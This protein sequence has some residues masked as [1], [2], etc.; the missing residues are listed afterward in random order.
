MSQTPTI[1]T[2]P[3][4][5]TSIDRLLQMFDAPDALEVAE[6]PR[7]RK[8]QIR[9]TVIVAAA[10]L[11]VTTIS[12][13]TSAVAD[14]VYA[15]QAKA[16]SIQKT[17]EIRYSAILGA[18]KK[19]AGAFNATLD[20]LT[21]TLASAVRSPAITGLSEA[22]A[23]LNT[24]LTTHSIDGVAAAR[25][26]VTNHVAAVSQNAADRALITVAASALADP[27]ARDAVTAAA[28]SLKTASPES[29]PAALRLVAAAST[30]LNVSQASAVAATRASALDAVDSQ[31]RATT[32][33]AA[34]RVKAAKAADTAD[35]NTAVANATA[36]AQAA[37]D[38]RAADLAAD[39]A[40][41]VLPVG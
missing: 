39:Q 34:A 16:A 35:L 2:E 3:T 31:V 40:A 13:A 15:S 21:D 10:V 19:S 14:T 17:A 20:G 11:T 27:D 8:A 12:P 9:N 32:R 5:T 30:A 4:N 33:A 41:A 26:A 1:D 29:V 25:L 23:A 18:D 6:D 24:S 38:Q 36:A 28:E 7:A 22:R 37:A